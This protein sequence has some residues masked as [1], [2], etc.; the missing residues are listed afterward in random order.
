MS[1]QA[2]DRDFR[3]ITSGAYRDAYL[4]YV[5]KSTDDTE[6]Q[7]N[8]IKYQKAET[9]RFAER[10]G[11]LVAPLT[12][13]GF[14]TDGVIAER[15]SG[16]KEGVELT[17]GDDN[18][19][20]YRVDR[21][22]FHRLV[23]LL[24]GRHFK[25]V[26]FLCWD[27]ASRNKGDDTILRK[28]MKAG[29]EVRFVLAQYDPT[30][31]GE[32]HMDIDGMFAEHH[33]RITREKV[34]LTIRSKREQGYVTHRAPVGYLNLGQMEH[35]PLDPERAPII[36]QLF[37]KAADTTWSLS[38]LQRW[39]IEHGLTMAPMRRRRTVDEIL[40]DE[41]EDGR[42]E[43]EKVARL[44]T[45][46][47]IHNILTN[48]FYIGR[49]WGNGGVWVRSA[50]HEALVSDGLF[51]RVQQ[52]LA[53][54]RTSIRYD[55]KLDHPFRGLVRCACGRVYSPYGQKGRLYYGARCG[56]S[57]S[58]QRKSVNFDLVAQTIGSALARLSFTD[59]ER[60]QIEREAA[61]RSPAL[62]ARREAEQEALERRRRKLR[63]DLSYL[64]ANRLTLLRTGVYTPDALAAEEI[65]LAQRLEALSSHDD[66]GPT[67]LRGLVADVLAVSELLKR[68]ELGYKIA[69]PSEKD[70]M[71]RMVI[72]ELTLGETALKV[73]YSEAFKPF[74]DRLLSECDLSAWLSELSTHRHQ[75]RRAVEELKSIMPRCDERGASGSNR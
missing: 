49:T 45:V 56:R 70:E 54:R 34:S 51:A 60:A 44:P 36:R 31:A 41:E 72:S 47:A 27:R 10:A 67:E 25:G 46:K 1:D 15:H 33:S 16:F 22:K 43:L 13:A 29:V 19:V 62:E 3:D 26:I 2:D 9:G 28:L 12:L 20:Q 61:Q 6:N 66:D 75:L 68:L 23:Q 21:P 42:S 52:R 48:P 39:A 57:C 7:K 40:A 24:A 38:D 4:I 73:S 35:K 69:K 63:E 30:S 14:C 17:F 32:L 74:E 64:T 11:L 59:D 55:K 37:E 5:R 50:S 65:N 18:T 58:N 71:A 8:S 53:G